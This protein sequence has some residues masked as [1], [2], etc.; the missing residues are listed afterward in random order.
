MEPIW[1]SP[2]LEIKV[3]G[4]KWLVIADLHLGFELDLAR[5][6]VYIPDQTQKMVKKLLSFKG[7]HGL[8]IAGDLKHSIGLSSGFRV[9]KFIEAVSPTFEEIVLVPGNHDG[10]IV[11]VLGD[12]CR[13]HGPRGVPLGEAWIFHGHAYPSE[14]SS[15]YEFGV[16]GHVHPAIPV[17][18][19][20]KIPVWI[21]AETTCDR[22]PQTI[23]VL[24][25]F[26][27]LLGYGDLL[28]MK[29]RGPV[30][31]KCIDPEVADVLTLDGHYLGTLAYLSKEKGLLSLT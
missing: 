4:K 15:N 8:L 3:N 29:K 13:I 22:L 12:C 14:E 10:G 7:F 17:K 2:A 9:R 6:G 20:G 27:D 24:P 1:G 16:M 30:F 23:V 31:P 18:G 11:A 21:I 25:P 19:I 26:N 5:Q 28:E